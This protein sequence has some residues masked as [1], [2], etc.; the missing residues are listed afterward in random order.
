MIYRKYKIDFLSLSFFEQQYLGYYDS[1]IDLKVFLKF[2]SRGMYLRFLV[3]SCCF[4]A[5]FFSLQNL[6]RFSFFFNVNLYIS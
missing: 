2:C 5:G 6:V 4:F 3:Y 1:S